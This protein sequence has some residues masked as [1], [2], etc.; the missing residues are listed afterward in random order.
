MKMHFTKWY[1][2][3]Y[4]ELPPLSLSTYLGLLGLCPEDLGAGRVLFEEHSQS[5][6]LQAHVT[7]GLG[8]L[9]GLLAGVDKD[10]HLV[11]ASVHHL[12]I[13]YI[14]HDLCITRMN[15]W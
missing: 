12:V 14:I 11:A 8:R 6:L 7:D 4:V 2:V 10:E 5:V 3:S 15:A 13:H 1:T 9:G